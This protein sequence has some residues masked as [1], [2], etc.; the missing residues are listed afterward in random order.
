MP[1]PTYVRSEM[2]PWKYGTRNVRTF[3]GQYARRVDHSQPR[4]PD[5]SDTFPSS[6]NGRNNTPPTPAPSTTET[7]RPP[8]NAVQTGKGPS[9]RRSAI[10]RN[11]ANAPYTRPQMYADCGKPD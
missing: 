5:R 10:T 4:A 7:P 11:S 8:S 1:C 2:S 9:R 6:D 3:G